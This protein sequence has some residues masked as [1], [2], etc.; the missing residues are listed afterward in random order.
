MLLDSSNS[1]S[2]STTLID[3]FIVAGVI[4]YMESLLFYIKS[5]KLGEKNL[6]FGQVSYVLDGQIR[7]FRIIQWQSEHTT[8][9]QNILCTVNK[10]F[11]LKRLTSVSSFGSPSP[12]SSKNIFIKVIPIMTGLG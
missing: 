1:A 9:Y 3:T 4:L 2:L 6:L 10:W 5:I 7:I 11:I 12:S 8:I